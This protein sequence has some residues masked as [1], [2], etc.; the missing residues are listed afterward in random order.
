MTELTEYLRRE[1][2]LIGDE[3]LRLTDPETKRVY[4]LVRAAMPA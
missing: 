1:L 2:K 3:P 4:V